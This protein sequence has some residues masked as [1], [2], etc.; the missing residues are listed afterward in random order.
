MLCSTVASPLRARFAET[1]P[2][3]VLLDPHDRAGIEGYLLERGL[4]RRSELPARIESAGSGNM[5]LTLR[6]TLAG[7]SLILKQG[8]PWVEKYDHIEAP[9]G[10]TLIEGGFYEAVRDVRAVSGRMPEILDLDPPHNVLALSD[11]GSRGDFTSIYQ[12]GA[13]SA[14]TVDELLDWL[15]ALG[16]VTIPNDRKDGFTNRAMRALNHEHI[17]RLPLARENGLD[18]DQI[19]EG[20][21]QA[22][23]DL[24][25]D[26]AYTARVHALGSRYLEDGAWLVHGDYFP[27]SW[28]KAA[29]G[30]RVI[31]P[32]FCFL[33]G[34]E[35]DYGV[36]L[37]HLA[38]ARTSVDPAQRV[39]EAARREDLDSAL[40]L[41]FAGVEVMR[42]LIGV[43][44]LSLPHD[45][46]AKRRLLEVSR[47]F[48]LTPEEELSCW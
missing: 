9:W 34:R 46:D 14:A 4:A 16:S 7:R 42:R 8:R 12:D 41:N 36:M 2:G 40:V 23:E 30:V 5:N 43:A 47:S 3:V 48:V 1:H 37:A 11:A 26:E 33:G 24:K 31:D 6:V 22:A 17:F 28:M 32:E 21:A 27:G 13:I 29:D 25:A 20:L 38:L 45:L 39:L 19:T 10:R 44:Q 18:L 15:R 35:F